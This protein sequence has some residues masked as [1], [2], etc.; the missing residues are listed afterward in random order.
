MI[1]DEIKKNQNDNMFRNPLAISRAPN[2]NGIR[3]FE[4]VPDNPPV[5]RKKTMIVP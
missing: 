4:N 1:I 5:K 2:C 3:I